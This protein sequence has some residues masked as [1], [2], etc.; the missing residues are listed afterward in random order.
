[1][2][3]PKEPSKSKLIIS[4]IS[5][6][7]ELINSSIN[8]ISERIS[9]P[10]YVSELQEFDHTEY[11]EDELGSGLKR[12][13]AAFSVLLK[14][15]DLVSVKEFTNSL[16]NETV[17][18]GKRR[19]NIDPGFLSIENFILATGKNFSH[20]VYLNRG[21]FAD[22]TLI[23]KKDKFC[24]LDWTYPDY[25]EDKVKDMLKKIRKATFF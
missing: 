13:F 4:F 11:Y 20:R 10:D 9:S 21:I 19:I 24:E 22:L 7:I 12:R 3:L 17:K 5:G 14:R 23:F 2:S 6:D 25:R 18:D 15:D 16:E 1:M 8:R